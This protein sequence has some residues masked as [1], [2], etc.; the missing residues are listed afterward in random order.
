MADPPPSG[1]AH[2]APAER[3]R[4]ARAGHVQFSREPAYTIDDAR[5]SLQQ[6]LF[7]GDVRRASKSL[8]L[9]K[10]RDAINE[11]SPLLT[12]RT[13]KDLGNIPQLDS[14]TSPDDDT[15]DEWNAETPYEYRQQ[16]SKSSW[17]MFL[18][19]LCMLG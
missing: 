18:L 5:S 3:P 11:Q 16:E 8:D 7:S 14:L 10:E 15:D 13:S 6:H 9:V 12:A 4:P 19:T 1:V 2:N 17:Y